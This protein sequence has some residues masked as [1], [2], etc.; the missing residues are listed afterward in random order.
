MSL[1]KLHLQNETN[2]SCPD[3]RGQGYKASFDTH[4]AAKGPRKKIYH[5]HLEGSGPRKGEHAVVK[6]FRAKPGTAAMCDAEI[7]KHRLALK[8]ARRFNKM[9]VDPRAKI[10]FTTPLKSTV[11]SLAL[12]QYLIRHKHGRHLD[13]M[14]WVLIEENLVR[15]GE[16][17]VFLGKT[18]E[19]LDKSPTSLDAFL[20][21]TFHESGQRF[22]LCGFQGVRTDTGYVLTTPCIH[23]VDSSFGTATDGGPTMMRKVFDQHICNNLCYCYERPPRPDNSRGE[24]H[25]TGAPGGD[26]ITQEKQ[27]TPVLKKL[28][29]PVTDSGFP[30]SCHGCTEP[31]KAFDLTVSVDDNKANDSASKLS[32]GYSSSETNTSENLTYCDSDMSR[33]VLDEDDD[34]FMRTGGKSGNTEID[35]KKTG[36][37]TSGKVPLDYQLETG[38]NTEEHIKHNDLSGTNHRCNV[39]VMGGIKKRP[40]L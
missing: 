12:G 18:G 4:S 36:P 6:V 9:V 28:H 17:Q 19:P 13:K 5:G 25:E 37:S 30:N 14:E 38:E 7:D 2:S 22:L 16:Y 10:S 33:S 31:Q 23:S 40:S 20:H 39:Q 24:E 11:E 1:L 8:L 29:L 35:E 21:F 3:F 32:S 15:Q 27:L 34:K 26:G